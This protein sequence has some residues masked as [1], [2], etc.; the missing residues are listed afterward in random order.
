MER[1]ILPIQRNQAR[2]PAKKQN[3]SNLPVL[4]VLHLNLC[5]FSERFSKI[6]HFFSHKINFKK[7]G[8]KTANHSQQSSHI[9]NLAENGARRG[10]TAYQRQFKKDGYATHSPSR[11]IPLGNTK[12]GRDY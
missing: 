10:E 12:L 11:K 9:Q 2:T 7:K 3:I 6:S 5:L 4:S 1:A 8:F